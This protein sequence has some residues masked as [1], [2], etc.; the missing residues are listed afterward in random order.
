MVE[1]VSVAR[2]AAALLL[3]A[4]LSG[5]SSPPPA[6]PD[7]MGGTATVSINSHPTGDRHYVSCAK[8]NWL[9][10]IE[11]GDTDTGFTAIVDTDGGP[12]AQVV[13]IRD[14]GG[15]TG[16]AWTGG[17]GQLRATRDNGRITISGTGY[18]YF[19][20]DRHRPATAAFDI[21]AGC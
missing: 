9:L 16:S 5:C 7:T 11:S 4:W 2:T 17:V 6:S 20:D 12:D 15:F 1:D 19:A 14:L 3:T 18:G 13:K 21:T 8:V 10:T